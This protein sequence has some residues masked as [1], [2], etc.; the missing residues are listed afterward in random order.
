MGTQPTVSLLELT[1]EVKDAV[2]GLPDELME[3]EPY[4]AGSVPSLQAEVKVLYS[5]IKS[6]ILTGKAINAVPA[7]IEQVQWA[8]ESLAAIER[9]MQ[10]LISTSE[11]YH[12][13]RD[14]K[15]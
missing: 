11:D 3:Q 15:I 10:L 8:A 1:T 2:I 6:L 14:T 7:N 9:P 13:C 5:R 4:T 12:D